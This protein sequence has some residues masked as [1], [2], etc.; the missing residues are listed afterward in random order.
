MKDALSKYQLLLLFVAVFACVSAS[1]TFK[2]GC[3]GDLK[4]GSVGD[5]LV[6][7]QLEGL[8]TSLA[9]LGVAIATLAAVCRKGYSSQQRIAIAIA[10]IFVG[11]V[12]ATLMGIQFEVWGAQTCLSSA[13]GGF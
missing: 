7:L 1:F 5:P 4:G 6:A 11:F 12:C 3:T 9:W 13:F 8:G 2:A 10:S